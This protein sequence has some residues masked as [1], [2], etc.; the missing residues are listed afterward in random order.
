M[1]KIGSYLHINIIRIAI[2]LS[3]FISLYTQAP[4][5]LGG[6]GQELAFY[7]FAIGLAIWLAGIILC[8]EKVHIPRNN[9]FYAF[10]FL[11]FCSFMRLR[12]FILNNSPYRIKCQ[13]KI[14]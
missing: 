10:A 9:S 4:S 6:L 7:P 2:V 3:G 12:N 11:F 8:R 5:W 1:Y 13:A 14:S